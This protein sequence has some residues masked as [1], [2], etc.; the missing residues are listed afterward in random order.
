MALVVRWFDEVSS[1]W[2]EE[3]GKGRREKEDVTEGYIGNTNLPEEDGQGL[4]PFLALNSWLRATVH[5]P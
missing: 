3:G 5:V 2:K 1:R 4:L